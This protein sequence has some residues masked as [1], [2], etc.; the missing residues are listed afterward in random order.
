MPA[1]TDTART[2]V[3]TDLGDPDI[4]INGNEIDATV[5]LAYQLFE[6]AGLVAPDAVI[7]FHRTTP[8]C[9][10]YYQ[11]HADASPTVEVCYT[12]E[13]P[14]GLDIQRLRVLSHELAH[15]YVEPRLDR[16]TR[17]A[18]LDLLGLERWTGDEWQELGSEHAAEVLVWGM[19]D[20][21]YRLHDRLEAL[22]R[23]TLDTVYGLLT[24]ADAGA[25]G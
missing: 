5:Q 20:G 10:G 12:S 11:S 21:Q 4:V 3:V 24:G 14:Q 16:P 13:N 15:A 2:I 6:G 8:A 7:R 9:N 19:L 17:V 23:S 22:D 25:T 18:L 1:P